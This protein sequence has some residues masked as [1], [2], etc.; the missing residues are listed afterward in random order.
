[1]PRKELSPE[2]FFGADSWFMASTSRPLRLHAL[3]TG[4]AAKQLNP[5]HAEVAILG[6]QMHVFAPVLRQD[7]LDVLDIFLLTR[8]A[9]DNF[10][11]CK[12]ATSKCIV[13]DVLPSC[14]WVFVSK[15]HPVPSHKPG[16]RMERQHGL[17]LVAIAQRV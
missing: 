13:H 3:T 8:V 9:S 14:H 4:N 5:L 10:L 11:G 7:L 2:E 17:G 12:L 6:G 16:A 15:R 1:M